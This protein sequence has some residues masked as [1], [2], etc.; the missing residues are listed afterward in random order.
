MRNYICIFLI[1]CLPLTLASETQHRFKV[2]VS[3]DGDNESVTTLLS[4]HLKRE[5]RA[6][7][8]VDVVRYNDNWEYYINIVYF[9]IKTVSGAKTG[10]L[11]IAQYIAR[12][13]PKFA[14]TELA[15]RTT[16]AV[17][18]GTGTLGVSH[19]KTENLQEWCI[20]TVGRFNDQKLE[21][22]R[23]FNKKFDDLISD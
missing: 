3:V 12:R 13:V 20:S 5:L 19:W 6:L 23:S 10:D 8:D 4:S 9:E 17:Y 2:Y 14:F 16:I 18:P 15:S 11:A 1:V 22:A 21:D 7:G